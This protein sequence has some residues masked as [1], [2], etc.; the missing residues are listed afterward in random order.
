[1]SLGPLPPSIQPS[2]TGTVDYLAT[3]DGQL[4]PALGDMA[5]Q[6]VQSPSMQRTL[7]DIDINLRQLC[8]LVH[9]LKEPV[10]SQP[11]IVPGSCLTL[12]ESVS[13]S[14]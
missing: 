14:V 13:R 12:P 1:M 7:Q 3:P 10:G 8:F 2:Q 9:W 4:T 6:T 5:G 11:V